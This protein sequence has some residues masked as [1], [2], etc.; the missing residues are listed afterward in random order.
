MAKGYLYLG[1]SG[2]A[3]EYLAD[4]I[5]DTAENHILKDQAKDLLGRLESLSTVEPQTIGLLLPLTG[6]F[7]RFGRQCMS[8]TFMALGAYNDSPAADNKYKNF[9]FA[10]RDSGDSI[11]SA[12]D[13]FNKLVLED[14]VIGVIG[15]L[16]SKQF[17]AVAQKAQEYG[18]P[19]LSLSQ[20]KGGFQEGAYVFPLALSPDQQVALVVEYAM[21]KRG[22]KRFAILAPND[23]FGEEYA[24]LFWDAV[25]NHNGKIVGY[26]KYTPKTTDFRDEAR[27]LLGL[28]YLEAR[29]LELE[30]LK[31]RADQYA[32]NIKVKGRMRQRLLD[33]F[34]PKGIA[35]FDALFIPDDPQTIGQ[36]APALAVE[37]VTNVPFLGINTWNSPEIIQRA[38]RYLQNSIFVDAFFAQS[39]NPV[40]SKFSKDYNALFNTNPG[41][42]EVQSFDAANLLLRALNSQEISTRGELRTALTNLGIYSGISGDFNISSAGVKRTARLLTIKGN[43]I[44]EIPYAPTLK[45]GT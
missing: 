5:D 41:S 9:K 12:L 43:Q 30:D 27:R 31:R 45:P 19:L 17:P 6:R 40:T 36:I 13:G 1:E 16:L 3:R 4:F 37:D 39:K 25:E 14:H 33:A 8:A 42:L 26:E 32:S 29:S 23:S 15:P 21:E 28:N 18:T 20:R 38:G 34:D 7:S 35:D 22:Y 11:E 10:I 24:N 2:R 44:V